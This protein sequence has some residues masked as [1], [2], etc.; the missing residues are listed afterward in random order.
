MIVQQLGPGQNV[1]ITAEQV[2]P[3]FKRIN[4]RKAAGPDRLTGRVRK[5]CREELG[6]IYS[7]LF[8]MS[9]DTHFV[10]RASKSA[11]IVPVPKP[12]KPQILNDYRPVA[13]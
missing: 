3:T 1:I 12:C 7:H 8:Q 2:C 4:I 13:S 5:A 6:F 9:V 10:P 11:L